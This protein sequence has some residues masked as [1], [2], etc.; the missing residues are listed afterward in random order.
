MYMSKIRIKKKHKKVSVVRK[1]CKLNKICTHNQYPRE[2]IY[3]LV[4][5]M[6]V[7]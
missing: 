4:G 2:C 7:K 5:K 1:K 6:E 3:N